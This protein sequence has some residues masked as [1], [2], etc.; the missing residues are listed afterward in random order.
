MDSAFC[1]YSW[2]IMFGT[3]LLN[4]IKCIFIPHPPP[5]VSSNPSFSTVIPIFF[6]GILLSYLIL[7]S[8]VFSSIRYSPYGLRPTKDTPVESGAKFLPKT[9]Y[10]NLIFRLWF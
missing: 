10:R 6:K 7:Y 5:A 2:F 3:T 8:V 1:R 9:S 4:K